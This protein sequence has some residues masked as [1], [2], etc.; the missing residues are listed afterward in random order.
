VAFL[1]AG[2]RVYSATGAPSAPGPTDTSKAT[3]LVATLGRVT[4]PSRWRVS[5]KR[6]VVSS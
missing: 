4:F 1:P 5:A 6:L 2:A 3:A